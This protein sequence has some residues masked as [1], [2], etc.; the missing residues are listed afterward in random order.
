LGYKFA[1]ITSDCGI[2]TQIPLSWR[3]APNFLT[4]N[5]GWETLK[6]YSFQR[7]LLKDEMGISIAQKHEYLLL[8]KLFYEDLSGKGYNIVKA[9]AIHNTHLSMAFEREMNKSLSLS[10][11]IWA[12]KNREEVLN[13]WTQR[14]NNYVWNKNKKNPIIYAVHGTNMESVW[15]ICETG[16]STLGL[17]DEGYYGKG[18]YCTTNVQYACF[19]SASSVKVLI[20]SVILPGNIYPVIENPTVKPNLL[21]CPNVPGYNSHG[22]LVDEKGFPL[23]DSRT[24]K[25]FFNELVIF[26]EPQ[27]CPRYV[28]LVQKSQAVLQTISKE[29]NNSEKVEGKEMTEISQEKDSMEVKERADISQENENVGVKEMADI[30]QEKENVEVKERADISQENDNEESI[31]RTTV[32]IVTED[33]VIQRKM[34]GNANPSSQST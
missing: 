6:P 25:A 4:E 10:N 27:I 24:A 16:F 9:Y 22:V 33:P 1:S 21:G 30:S 23:K 34:W 14:C 11:N 18:I 8:E 17:V 3:F 12:D 28:I 29:G 2:V 26:Q 20:I 15:K 19:Y 5:K 7:F 13:Y 32:Q 31:E